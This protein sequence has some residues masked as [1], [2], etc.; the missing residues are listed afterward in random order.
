M[1]IKKKN[2]FNFQLICIDG[3]F[4]SG[5][6]LIAPLLSSYRNVQNQQISYEFDRYVILNFLK[7]L[8][9]F[10]SQQ[11]IKFSTDESVFNYEI[12]R[13]LNLRKYDHTGIKYNPNFREDIKKIFYNYEK[14]KLALLNNNS[15][16]TLNLMTHKTFIHSNLIKSVFKKKKQYLHI[17]MV[18]NP[19]FLFNHYY[20]FFKKI[21][22]KKEKNFLV[23]IDY[24]KKDYPW[25]M[26]EI[27]KNNKKYNISDMIVIILKY[28]FNKIKIIK[29]YMIIIP[30]EEFVINPDFYL[31]KIENKVV[32]KKNVTKLK[33]QMILNKLPRK[34]VNDGVK[35][36]NYGYSSRLNNT[37]AYEK[38]K[39][40][41]FKLLSKS[42][43]LEF[44]ELIKI[45]NNKY[46]DKFA[47]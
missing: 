12:G 33:R 22:K 10:S 17:I 23:C 46:S 4:G 45:Y 19:I 28:L 27:L 42:T 5:K 35:F 6:T 21:F 18:R 26:K 14:K 15:K 29:N 32:I 44:L 30:F 16:I 13:N 40:K 8:D 1:R 7:K 37:A 38:E 25:F 41:I 47:R 43:K 3:F 36:V 9:T 31:R 20:N 39:R 34:Y 11:M 2:I 24:K